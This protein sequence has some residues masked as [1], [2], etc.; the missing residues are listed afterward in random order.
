[1]L[2]RSSTATNGVRSAMRAPSV[3]ATGR[4]ASS[5][6]SAR[7]SLAGLSD[8]LRGKSVSR[9]RESSV[10]SEERGRARAESP[11]T[12]GGGRDQ[13]RGRKTALKVLREALT[14]GVEEA[15]GETDEEDE[16]EG[17]GKARAKGWK[18]FRAG[19]YTYPI[20]IP[21]PA[22][23]PPTITSDFGNVA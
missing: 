20:A 1:M 17:K 5:R 7:F 9:A 4:S 8:A 13:S 18:E 14:S 23:L 15:V 21:I 3:A 10:A 6:P 2:F 11:D 12:R 22:S 16:N 19:T